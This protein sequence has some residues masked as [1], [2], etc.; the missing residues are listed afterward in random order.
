MEALLGSL[1]CCLPG[2]WRCGVILGSSVGCPGV[3][4]R[5]VLGLCWVTVGLDCSGGLI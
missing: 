4:L 2:G 5:S 3:R 1:G